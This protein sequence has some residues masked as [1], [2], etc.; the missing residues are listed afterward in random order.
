M[1]YMD[2]ERA[3]SKE[4]K[5]KSEALQKYNAAEF[6]ERQNAHYGYMKE[7]AAEFKD[8]R[9]AYLAKHAEYE[10]TLGK[11]EPLDVK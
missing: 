4:Y 1:A 11:Y 9:K 8:R 6:K 2:K 5:A 7:K 10:K 3:T